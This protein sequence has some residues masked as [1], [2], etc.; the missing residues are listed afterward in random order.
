MEIKLFAF[1]C[2]NQIFECAHHRSKREASAWIWVIN[3]PIPH[4]HLWLS[5]QPS[6]CLLL[7]HESNSI[8]DKRLVARIAKQHWQ[9]MSGCS[10]GN[11]MAVMKACSIDITNTKKIVRQWVNNQNFHTLTPAS[12]W[13]RS[14]ARRTYQAIDKLVSLSLARLIYPFYTHKTGSSYFSFIPQIIINNTERERH[15]RNLLLAIHSSLSLSRSSLT[16]HKQKYFNFTCALLWSEISCVA[17][18][19][20]YSFVYMKSLK[21]M[22]ASR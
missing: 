4:G 14:L 11:G 7:W 20:G 9:S 6:F 2:D 10:G 19:S 5:M 16:K 1:N 12:Q 8:F 3:L 17:F 18:D 21:W 22:R 13:V 15:S